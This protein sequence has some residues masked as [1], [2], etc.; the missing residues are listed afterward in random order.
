MFILLI[1]PYILYIT[2]IELYKDPFIVSY[3]LFNYLLIIIENS[4]KLIKV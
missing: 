4:L 2:I 3:N 1:K